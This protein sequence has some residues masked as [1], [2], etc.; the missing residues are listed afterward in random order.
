MA[1][2][3][4]HTKYLKGADKKAWETYKDAYKA[5]KTLDNFL[6]GFKAPVDLKE[7]EE[8]EIPVRKGPQ[9]NKKNNK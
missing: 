1:V 8:Y 2:D 6:G 5:A 7:G 9:N 4:T 3:N